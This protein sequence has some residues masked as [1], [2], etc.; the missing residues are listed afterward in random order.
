MNNLSI[1][2]RLRLAIALVA[3]MFSLTACVVVEPGGY[4]HR[5]VYLEPPVVVHGHCR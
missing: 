1:S 4:R 3:A 5:P 2:R